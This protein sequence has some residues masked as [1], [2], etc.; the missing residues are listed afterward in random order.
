[1]GPMGQKRHIIYRYLDDHS[2][3][4]LEPLPDPFS[5][6]VGDIVHRSGANWRIERIFTQQDLD[7]PNSPSTI[8]VCLAG[9]TLH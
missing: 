1:V 2:S 5:F 9:V 6:T 4:E 7:D 8:W 3:D